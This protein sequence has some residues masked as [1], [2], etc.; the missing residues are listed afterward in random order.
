M[1]L[2][3]LSWAEFG[4]WVEV[5]AKEERGRAAQHLSDHFLASRGAD[6]ALNDRLKELHGR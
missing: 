5:T 6:T 4:A 2:R 3:R 1:N